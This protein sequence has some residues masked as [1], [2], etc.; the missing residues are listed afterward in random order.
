MGKFKLE[1]G[2]M[3]NS[4]KEIVRKLQKVVDD[5]KKGYNFGADWSIEEEGW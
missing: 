3:P 4:R 2:N 1:V 5:I